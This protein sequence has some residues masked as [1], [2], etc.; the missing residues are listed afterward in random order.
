MTAGLPANFVQNVTQSG[1]YRIYAFDQGVLVPD[2]TYA[3]TIVKDLQKTY[4]GEVRS[5]VDTNPWVKNSNLGK[6]A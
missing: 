2:R 6:L 1:V 3:M 4:W 5:L